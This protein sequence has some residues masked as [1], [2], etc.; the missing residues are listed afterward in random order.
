[1]SCKPASGFFRSAYQ[2]LL[3]EFLTSGRKLREVRFDL[4]GEV[5]PERSRQEL[6]HIPCVLKTS[7]VELEEDQIGGPNHKGSSDGLGPFEKPRLPGKL[8]D[9]DVNRNL[10]RRLKPHHARQRIGQI[11]LPD[12]DS[13]APALQDGP[14]IGFETG[15]IGGKQVEVEARPVDAVSGQGESADQGVPDSGRI[16]DRADLLAQ[17][18]PMS[19]DMHF[20]G[21][22][23][24]W[25]WR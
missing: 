8:S 25:R 19:S 2:D 5:F 13:N 22:R 11:P 23:L 14:K 12:L 3:P 7:G 1:M 15:C 6:L 9:H 18:H 4:A 17:A 10:A 16:Q 20:E 21:V 24:A